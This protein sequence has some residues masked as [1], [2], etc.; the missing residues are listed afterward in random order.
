VAV[1]RGAS[2]RGKLMRIDGIEG[3]AL[4]ERLGL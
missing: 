4:R 2:G 1:I 3:E